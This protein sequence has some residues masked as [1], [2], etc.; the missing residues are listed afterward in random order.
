MAVTHAPQKSTVGMAQI[1]HSAQKAPILSFSSTPQASILFN[2]LLGK[3]PKQIPTAS[4]FPDS[5]GVISSYMPLGPVSTITNPFFSTSI[6]TNG[7]SCITYHVPQSGWTIS[8]PQIPTIYAASSGKAPLF[9]PV[10]SANCP[11]TL[12]A[13]SR[14]SVQFFQAHSQL[15]SRGNFR[16]SLNAPNSGGPA[17]ETTFNGS[18]P[19]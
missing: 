16:I 1:V 13:T 5:L 11:D 12:G 18:T 17:N 15:F 14:S 4:S 2:V 9:Q 6:T 8:P 7:R 3:I 10:D 19:Q